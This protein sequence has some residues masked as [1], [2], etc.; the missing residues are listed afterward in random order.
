MLGWHHII[1][2]GRRH[3]GPKEDIAK[4][5]SNQVMKC[6]KPAPL[7]INGQEKYIPY[8]VNRLKKAQRSIET[9]AILK[10]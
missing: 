3:Q 5:A 8:A 7:G 4:L 9:S 6:N 1:H 10:I 2:Y